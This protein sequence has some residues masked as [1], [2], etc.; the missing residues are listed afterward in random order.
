[1]SENDARAIGEQVS[2]LE[3]EVKLWKR[4]ALVVL[5]GALVAI[6]VSFSGSMGHA[7]AAVSGAG[8][9][10][11]KSLTVVDGQGTRRIGLTVNKDASGVSLFDERGRLRIALI[12]SKDGHQV[13]IADEK[14]KVRANLALLSDGPAL[15]LYDEKGAPRAVIEV[16]KDHGPL[17][18][19]SDENGKLKWSAP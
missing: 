14:G 6:S 1:M 7:R 4:G 18:V 10:V 9:L 13:T 5:L 17:A 3:G 16:A 2:R 11:V 8:D 12:N 15:F 19:F